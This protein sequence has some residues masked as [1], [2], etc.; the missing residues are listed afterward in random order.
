MLE[1]HQ[2]LVLMTFTSGRPATNIFRPLRGEISVPKCIQVTHEQTFWMVTRW[3][4]KLVS[5]FKQ[6]FKFLSV[7]LTI[8]SSS[9]FKSGR[10]FLR[11]TI[12]RKIHS[13]TEWDACYGWKAPGL[14]PCK[15][16][17]WSPQVA[18]F[19]PLAKASQESN[20]SYRG[21]PLWYCPPYVVIIAYDIDLVWSSLTFV[22]GKWAKR[23]TSMGRVF[24][25]ILKNNGLRHQ[26]YLISPWS[27]RI[28]SCF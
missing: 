2:W 21:D 23:R 25:T 14:R 4:S 17:G 9:G 18:Q 28:N 6:I 26:T 8:C 10:S 13:P 12:T 22:R 24:R 5:K 1:S 16:L 19:A 11:L 27:S 20:V 7:G 3:R 15:F